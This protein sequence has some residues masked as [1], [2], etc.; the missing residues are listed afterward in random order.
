MVLLWYGTV[1]VKAEIREFAWGNAVSVHRGRQDS[2]GMGLLV[3]QFNDTGMLKGFCLNTKYI[4]IKLTVRSL[5]VTEIAG[6]KSIC[7]TPNRY[8]HRNMA[9]TKA[10]SYH[11]VMALV[12]VLHRVP[13]L[14]SLI[15]NDRFILARCF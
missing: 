8:Q 5:L 12:N 3:V 15:Y 1:L 6:I 10:N 7:K 9:S 4:C 2:S 13:T 14:L 11:H